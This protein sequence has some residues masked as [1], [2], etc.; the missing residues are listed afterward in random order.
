MSGRKVNA[1]AAGWEIVLLALIAAST[2]APNCVLVARGDDAIRPAVAMKAE[3]FSLQ[4]VRLLEGPFQRAMELD[5]K[6]LLSLEPDRLLH[7]FRINAGLPSTAKPYGGWMA[8]GHNSRGEF[9]GHYLSACALM[10]ASTGDGQLK[11]KAARVVAGLA[12]CQEKLGTG[13][14]H[15]H[16]DTFTSRCEGPVP[17]WYQI[18]KVLAG[19]L[20]VHLYCGNPQAL[21]VARKLGDWACR[22]AEK[23]PD[24]RIQAMLDAEHGGINEALANLAGRTG[25]SKY[26]KLSLRFNHLAVLGPPMKCVDA[27]DGLHANTQI[28]KFTGAARQYELTGDALLATAARFFWESVVRE[29]SYVIGGNSDG[30]RFTPK[31]TLSR[32][33]SPATCETCNTYNMLKLTRHLFLWDPRAEYADYYERALYNHILAS[34]NPETGMMFYFAPLN[35]PAK[36]FGTPDDSFWC[37]YGTGIENH[38]KYGDSIYFHDGGN[39]L[40]VNLF[41][42]SEL[43]WKEQGLTLRQ[44]TRFPESETSRL[45]FTCQKPVTLTVHVRYP[46]WAASGIEIAVNGRRQAVESRPGSYVSVTREWHTDDA[47]EIR[48][49]MTVHTGAFRDNPRK[50]AILY[51]P[52][53]LCSTVEPGKPAPEIVCPVD[54]IPSDIEPAGKPLCFKGSPAIFRRPG[55]EQGVAVTLVPY[56]REYR[57]P[58]VVYWDVLAPAPAAPAALPSA[59]PPTKTAAVLTV[60]N[61]PLCRAAICPYQYG[62]F[63]EYLCGLTPSMFAEQVF[64]GSFEG[65]P[66]YRVEFRK[67]TDRLEKPWYPDGAVHRGE[68]VLDPVEP[69]NGKVSQRITQKPGDPCTLG[70]SQEGKHVKAGQPLRCSLHLRARGLQSPVQVAIWGQGRTYASASFQPTPQWQP[71]ETVLDPSGTAA[72]AT[73]TISFR[74]PGTLWIDQVSLMPTDNVFGWRRDVAEALKALRPGIIRFGGSTTEGF[75]W[76]DTLGEPAKRVPFTTCW[77]GLEPGNAGLEEFVQLCRWVGAEPLICVRFTGRTPQQAAEQ[78]E[79]FNGPAT[80]PMGKLRLANGHAAPYGVRF[81]QIG[82]ELGDESYQKGIVEFSKA[83]K[84][85]DPS[86]KLLAAFPSP[87]LLQR[88]GPWIDYICPHHYGCHNLAAMEGDVARCR[89]LIADN[90]PGRTIRLGITEWNTTAGDFG[91]G[92][93]MLWTLDNALWCSRY[94]NFMHRHCDMIEIANRSNLADSFCS[95]IIQTNGTGLFKTPTYY[96]Q[97]LY[98]T[99]AGTRP[100][101]IHCNADLRGDPALDISAT[102]SEDGRRIALFAVNPTTEPQ[103]R[104]LDL[105][106]L[107]P[108]DQRVQVWT[109]ADT[110][111]AGERDAANSWRQPDRIRTEPGNAAIGGAKLAYCFPPLSLTVLEM[112]PETA[113]A[114]SG[115]SGGNQP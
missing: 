24:S 43:A 3:P 99:H 71:F 35:G 23:F 55:A 113:P 32:A 44:E 53:V 80:T 79:Y 76:T 91:L 16:A 100:L 65:V 22:A 34:Q 82:N 86:V 20:E 59:A 21:D 11:E 90:A 63:I 10:Y 60:T 2:I 25:D 45:I 27:L 87:G 73:L 115:Q 31:A 5:H 78:V 75:Q 1:A 98:A 92:R 14:L 38:A 97:Q 110:L 12:E 114:P 56:Y 108:L 61:E 36:S 46:S 19:L 58:H 40:F 6:Y 41:V 49:P 39:G 72:A 74:G 47:V 94:H 101:K 85:V 103:S 48:A 62:Q 52:L 15:T 83:M 66:P 95:G 7:V 105:S 81:W 64:D 57:E 89:K 107:A 77:G 109:L 30:E 93:A 67:E 84:G 106:A 4:D 50:V 37:C 33:L 13:F 9:V 51:G 96:A 26:L 17:F 111:R 28:P 68:F 18:H 112:Q 70:I 42:A 29:R 54:R 88:A 102:L 8:P 69:F 104:R